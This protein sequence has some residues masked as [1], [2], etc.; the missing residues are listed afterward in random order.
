M[1]IIREKLY[2]RLSKP[3]KEL[4]TKLKVFFQY[5]IFEVE[6]FNLLVSEDV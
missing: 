5:L 6:T 2:S 1:K 4:N 3:Y